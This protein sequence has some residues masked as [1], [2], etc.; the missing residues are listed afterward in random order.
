M[1]LLV[2]VGRGFRAEDEGL[3]R[4]LGGGED[5]VGVG[6][7]HQAE[8]IGV[9]DVGSNRPLGDEPRRAE[10]VVVVPQ[11]A[12]VDPEVAD[13]VSEH[14]LTHRGRGRRVHRHQFGCD[15]GDDFVKGTSHVCSGVDCYA[16]RLLATAARRWLLTD[17]AGAS[18]NLSTRASDSSGSIAD[19]SR[20]SL[21]QPCQRGRVRR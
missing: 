20:K 1:V 18:A 6:E 10:V 9:G 12:E 2:V 4:G 3:F 17:V 14:A 7:V 21:L 16:K 13:E 15:G 11:E 19:S 8:R 5:G